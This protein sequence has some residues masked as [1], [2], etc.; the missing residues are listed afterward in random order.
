MNIHKRIQKYGLNWD[1]V[2]VQKDNNNW[3]NEGVLKLQFG[4]T[5]MGTMLAH[6][7]YG[8]YM[9]VK[10]VMDNNKTLYN[11]LVPQYFFAEEFEEF[12]GI[13]LYRRLHDWY[14]FPKNVLKPYENNK[15]RMSFITTIGDDS[16]ARIVADLFHYLDLTGIVYVENYRRR[17]F[18]FVDKSIYEQLPTQWTIHDLYD[19]N[20]GYYDEQKQL[21]EILWND[22]AKARANHE[23]I[24][25]PVTV[26]KYSLI[27]VYSERTTPYGINFPTILMDEEKQKRIDEINRK[28]AKDSQRDNS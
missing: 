5:F 9:K 3:R 14:T 19:M 7:I 16:D 24:K 21:R 23:P 25:I 4:L 22:I 26:D 17:P 13:P 12:V 8:P 2:T 27:Q 15:Y 1:L 28:Y 20:K 6:P 11:I 10:Y 18:L